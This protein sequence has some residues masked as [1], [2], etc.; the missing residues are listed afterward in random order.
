MSYRP[1][2]LLEWVFKQTFSRYTYFNMTGQG[3]GLLAKKCKHVD[4]TFAFINNT[5]PE[6][7]TE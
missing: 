2:Y 5:W 3:I 1:A 4:Y 6:T 7:G